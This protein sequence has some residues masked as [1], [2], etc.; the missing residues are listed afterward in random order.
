MF[1]DLE[2]DA[3]YLLGP[4]ES[5]GVPGQLLHSAEVIEG[6]VDV[7]HTFDTRELDFYAKISKD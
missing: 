6:P 3:D 4:G 2:N 1:H 5:L 7:V